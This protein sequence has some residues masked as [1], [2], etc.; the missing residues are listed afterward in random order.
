MTTFKRTATLT[1]IVANP[2]HQHVRQDLRDVQRMHHVLTTLACPPD[3]GPSSRAAASLLYRVEH[4]ATGLHILMQS[5]TQPDPARLTSGYAIA[6]TT[7]LGP[8]LDH[9]DTGM[10]VRYRIIANPTKCSSRGSGHRGERRPLAGDE[11]VTW[12]ERKANNSGLQLD[13]IENTTHAKLTGNR[14]KNGQSVRLTITT[15]TFEGTAHITEPAAVQDAILTGIGRARAY[16]CG[17]LSLAPL[18]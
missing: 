9:L 16:G 13:N 3:F 7:D 10:H 8:L 5:T 17:L 12:W 2:S 11:A 6:A 14:S 15:T 1:K 4:T 18:S